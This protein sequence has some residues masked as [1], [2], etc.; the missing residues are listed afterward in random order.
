[1]KTTLRLTM[2]AIVCVAIA[3]CTGC[4]FTGTKRHLEYV[5]TRLASLAGRV[6]M[7]PGQSSQ[8]VVAV[9]DSRTAQ[10]EV[11]KYAI[12]ATPGTFR[13]SVAAPG[14]YGVLAFADL[15]GNLVLDGNEPVARFDELERRP[16][17]PG[18]AMQDIHLALG[19][20]AASLPAHPPIRVDLSVLSPTASTDESGIR[21]SVGEVVT[22]SDPRFS[23][24]HAKIGLWEPI[25]FLKEVG[26]GV[27][28]LQP[29]D[30]HRIP[31]LFIHGADAE[32][33]IWRYLIERLDQSRLQP[34]LYYY[35]SGLRLTV[36]SEA[37]CGMVS[38]LR[39]RY[40]VKSLYVVAHSMGGLVQKG[41]LNE[42]QKS[43]SPLRV[44][45]A[46]SI[47]TPWGGHEA[48]AM[49]VKNAPAVVPAWHDMAP[50]SPFL[51]SLWETP[52][53]PE[54]RFHLL[55]SYDGKYSVVMDR[56]NDGAVTLQSQLNDR[57]QDAA[58]RLHGFSETHT[59][60]LSSEAVSRYLNT[61][62]ESVGR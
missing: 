6:T 54:T 9:W 12:M 22:L 3:L 36:A 25:R 56:N 43:R 2:Q 47:S 26:I 30:R 39:A 4:A 44:P 37:L 55:F 14:N 61:L 45:V 7:P 10:A 41:F 27:Y 24:D 21:Y 1:M 53:P 17:I 40:Q 33:G 23:P 5:Q 49:G 32:P 11:L 46:V 34:W 62:L 48:A 15:N 38:E 8:V 20:G 28:C 18:E 16:I 58:C 42:L 31:V 57:A 52:S 13:I 60:I 50:G 19:A 29:F 35:P 51:A 59:G